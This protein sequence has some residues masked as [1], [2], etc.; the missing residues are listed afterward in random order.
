[1]HPNYERLANGII[2]QRHV[3]KITYNYDYS[4]QYNSY[5]EK[6]RNLSH[7][8]FGVLLGVLGHT[9]AS[10]VDVGYGNGD[11]L[12]VCTKTIPLV[13][14]CDLSD[15]PVPDSC[16][17]I[18]LTEIKNVEVVCFFDS[19]EHV[20]D[21]SFVQQLDTQY[22]FV[23]VPWCHYL[24]HEWFTSWYHRRENEH[25]YHFNEAA[26]TTFFRESG[27]DCIYTSSFEDVIRY[28]PAVHPLPNILSCIF[29]KRV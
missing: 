4:N 29:K 23:S 3:E 10:I 27:Y 26:L 9:P 1:M 7:L 11:F 6:G 20:D 16:K 21:L 25:L 8:R 28:N 19:L 14:G 5:G 22:I 15:Y 13:Y 18:T 17:K 2:K 24:S 12:S